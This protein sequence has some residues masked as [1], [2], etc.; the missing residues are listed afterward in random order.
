MIACCGYA[1]RNAAAYISRLH[2]ELGRLPQGLFVNGVTA[3]EGAVRA[4]AFLSKEQCEA[5]VFG[6]FDWDPFAARLPF[7]VIM[8][9][10]DVEAMI[11]EAFALIDRPLSSNENPLILVPTRFAGAGESDGQVE[12]W[13]IDLHQKAASR[14]CGAQCLGLNNLPMPPPTLLASQDGKS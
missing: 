2:A 6:C 11:A 4:L 5:I 10:Q 13:D 8:V 12:D 9:R 7:E 3:L 14:Q 1:P